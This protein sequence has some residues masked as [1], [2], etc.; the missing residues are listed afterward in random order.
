MRLRSGRRSRADSSDRSAS[1]GSARERPNP[2]NRRRRW[3]FWHGFRIASFILVVLT[4]AHFAYSAYLV[5]HYA[6]TDERRP[7]DAIVVLGAAQYNGKPSPVL[8]A[9]LDHAASLWKAKIAPVIVVTGGKIEGDTHTEAGASAAYLATL[10]VP[11]RQ[12]LREVQGRTSWESL[13]AASNFMQRRGI[14]SVVLVSDPFHDA[15]IRAMARSLGLEAYVS[16][17]R[18]SPLGGQT[19]ARYQVKEVIALSV[20]RVVG[21]DTIARFERSFV[22]E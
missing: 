9:R 10:G 15:R 3:G 11:D 12:I 21:F 16:P 20:G 5:R 13:Q 22:A 14:R 8:Q 17:T 19:V 7:V 4:I 18:T 2:S 1:D 6:R